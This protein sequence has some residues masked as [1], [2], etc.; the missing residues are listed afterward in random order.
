MKTRISWGYIEISSYLVNRPSV[1]ETM[2]LHFEINPHSIS[3]PK[4]GPQGTPDLGS[5][6]EHDA[7]DSFLFS[8]RFSIFCVQ[9]K[10]KIE[11][12]M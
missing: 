7:M 6:T 12:H 2:S 3:Q 5:R 1:D 10:F 8:L 9:K 11:N 4:A